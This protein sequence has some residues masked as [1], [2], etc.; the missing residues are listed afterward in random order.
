M[1]AVGGSFGV[2]AP[3]YDDL[4]LI[5]GQSNVG[6][7]PATGRIAYALMPGYLKAYRRRILQYNTTTGKFDPFQPT[8]D[9]EWGWLVEFIY[10]RF[11][12]QDGKPIY[13]YKFGEG[14]TRLAESG[15]G[16][17][18][19][20]TT[21]ERNGWAAILAFR[22]YVQ[23]P[24]VIFLWDH[25]YTDGLDLVNAQEYVYNLKDFF[26]EV[27]RYWRLP[28]LYIV[29]TRLSANAT[30]STN[31]STVQ[32]SQDTVAE[33]LTTQGYKRNYIVNTDN[34]PYQADGAHYSDK[35]AFIA[36]ASL[37]RQVEVANIPSTPNLDSV[38]HPVYLN[39]Y[40]YYEAREVDISNTVA[41]VRQSGAQFF[42]IKFE[43]LT[44]ADARLKDVTT[45][46]QPE[47]L[48]AGGDTAYLNF[49]LAHSLSS[50]SPFLCET[51]C[52][53]SWEL[54]FYIDFNDGQPGALR[55]LFE[56]ISAGDT[57]SIFIDAANKLTARLVNNV[58]ISAKTNVATFING[59]TGKKLVNIRV[60]YGAA[61]MS[62]Y[63]D[64][65][66]QTL[67]ATFN[68][69]LTTFS[70]TGFIPGQ[71]ALGNRDTYSAT[72]GM[73]AR[74]YAFG[75]FPLLDATDRTKV[76]QYLTF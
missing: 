14:G 8:S 22:K 59:Q 5:G 34:A 36:A 6:D 13:F 12:K 66:V 75:V 55:V 20:R 17:F 61:Q 39:P 38:F 74:L 47:V 18:Y 42:V 50:T 56:A 51:F 7:A 19:T 49:V 1:V 48:N 26:K 46:H 40:G 65:A 16:A 2:S 60:D 23:N 72:T 30:S 68:G 62:I 52:Q 32:A 10:Q 69:V 28:N 4:Y 3:G 67:D 45:T 58:D 63:V 33:L 70:T 41:E 29:Y 35:G 31:G 64:G 11:R 43:N 71:F 21:L 9:V 24:R 25:G 53:S 73:D 76:E 15:S 57:I 37:D 54:F 27:R 44:G